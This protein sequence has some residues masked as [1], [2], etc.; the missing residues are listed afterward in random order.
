MNERE[1][2]RSF[3]V[4]DRAPDPEVL[5]RGRAA[6]VHHIR[7]GRP[8]EDRLS[9][10]PSGP[11]LAAAAAVLAVVA[12]TAAVTVAVGSGQGRD[13]TAAS[14]HPPVL[15][16]IPGPAKTDA[17]ACLGQT[18]PAAG[19]RDI[20]VSPRGDDAST[21][22]SA[23][24]ALA[25]PQVAVDRARPGD[26]VLLMTGDYSSTRESVIH[27]AQDGRSG[28]E[29]VLTAAP[30]EHPVIRSGVD[31]WKAISVTGSHVIV[32][33]LTLE[34]HKGLSDVG[35]ARAHADDVLARTAGN[36]IFVSA[37]HGSS[38]YPRDV[39]VRGNIVRDFPGGGI[40]ATATGDITITCNDVSGN[41]VFSPYIND[42]IS[43][44]GSGPVDGELGRIT[45]SGN[46]VHDNN[47][48]VPSKATNADPAKRTT[49]GGRGII[50]SGMNTDRGTGVLLLENNL[51]YANG[52]SGVV[53]DRCD[54][55]TVL[56]TTSA[57]NGTRQDAR[58]AEI[59]VYRSA[60]VELTNNLV[61]PDA[62]VVGISGQP[63]VSQRN[64]EAGPTAFATAATG[65]FRLRCDSPAVDEGVSR[66]ATDLFGD[67]RPKGAGSDAG[68]IESC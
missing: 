25:D 46:I 28:H 6:L 68:A 33:G 5:V 48:L 39:V 22:A 57:G 55:A 66:S 53:I 34:G 35:Y 18:A 2:L 7:A 51:V 32:A 62:R 31:N 36:G 40:G 27:I 45:I 61:V 38:Q 49:V 9:R 3:R 50:C 30:G 54:G 23:A 19:G 12:V 16:A 21:G 42:G 47:A 59:S 65:D 17:P 41:A 10:R 60:R 20:W 14:S 15:S 26:R 11:V 44:G 4:P 29:I 43:V 63:A 52:G 67:V 8:G 58:M 56:H 24:E 1:L 37:D 13:A 64:V